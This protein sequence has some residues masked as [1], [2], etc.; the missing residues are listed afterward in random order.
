M[1]MM[2]TRIGE[3]SGTAKRT[4]KDTDGSKNE[5]RSNLNKRCL[6]RSVRLCR[7][8]FYYLPAVELVAPDRK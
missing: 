5:P 1:I 8:F 6:W 7:I 2:L 3:D 4:F